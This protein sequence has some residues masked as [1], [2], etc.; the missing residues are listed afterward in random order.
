MAKQ[1]PGTGATARERLD[2]HRSGAQDLLLQ[3]TPMDL[4]LY[5]ALEGAIDIHLHPHPDCVAR[6]LNDVEAAAQA[7]AVGMRAIVIKCH[8]SATPDRAHIAEWTVGGGIKVYGIICLNPSLGG[9]NPAAVKMAIRM[10]AKGVWMPSMSD[11]NVQYTRQAGHLMGDETLGTEFPEKGVTIL[12][13]D[14]RIK[15]EAVEILEQVAEA[16]IMLSTG[17][18]SLKEAHVLLDEANKVGVKKL[19][20]HTVNFHPMGYPLEDQK[21]MVEVNG[22]FLEYG[23]SSLPDPIWQPVDPSRRISLDDVCESIRNVG[24]E[25]CILS[26]DSGQFTTPTPIECMRLWSELLKVKGF[27]REEYDIMAKVNPARLL[28]LGP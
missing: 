6:L 22:A 2:E 17:H 27:T 3:Q 15:P 7:K 8:V 13:E 12:D 23:Y 4:R 20:V 25:N 18:L 1:E 14:G 26:T 19:V 28:G 21:K 16:D 9:L 24:V 10:G 11:H 5:E